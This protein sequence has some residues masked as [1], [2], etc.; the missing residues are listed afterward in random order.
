MIRD[1]SSLLSIS[2]LVSLT[3][4]AARIHDLS[5][6]TPHCPSCGLILCTLHPA[7]HPCPSCL[8][9]ILSPAA[10]AR[11]LLRIQDDVDAQ[12]AREQA[13]RDEVERARIAA[14]QAQ[15]AFPY[16]SG[17]KGSGIGTGVGSGP[18][19]Q[20]VPGP[21]GSEGRKVLTIGSKGKGKGKAK[22]T[23]LTTTY[24]RPTPTPSPQP[25]SSG[26]NSNNKG[27]EIPS[28]IIPRPRSAPMEKNRTDKELDKALRWR[29]EE[30][31]PWGDQKVDKK[32]EGWNYL[33]LPVLAIGG[34][35]QVG[36]RRKKKGMGTAQGGVG[37][38][39]RVVVGAA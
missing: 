7:H 39:G 16:L 4:V 32:G 21:P 28:D 24:T 1:S 36:R 38:D 14:V 26:A 30:D 10:L 9:P 8:H 23:T 34:E 3:Q 37:R 6:Y 2:L 19:A 17:T 31:R 33:P 35:D 13:A 15:A 20:P 18:L 5:P 29:E 27:D 25:G 22:T 12:L 11:L